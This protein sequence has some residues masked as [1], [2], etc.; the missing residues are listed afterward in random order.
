[1]KKSWRCTEI[2]TLNAIGGQD[3]RNEKCEETKEKRGK[4][5]SEQ[6]NG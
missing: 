5:A 3:E 1:V 6:R 2:A 4:N